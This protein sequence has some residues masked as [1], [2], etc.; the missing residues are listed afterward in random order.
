M[1]SRS[2]SNDPS[3][4]YQ[5]DVFNKVYDGFSY[6]GTSA[7]VWTA[8]AYSWY[9]VE[10]IGYDALYNMA[11]KIITFNVVPPNGNTLTV[12]A[13]PYRAVFIQQKENI[14]I[15]EYGEFQFKILD[16]TIITKEGARQ[17]AFQ[18]IL[19]WS[20]EVTEAEFRT[21]QPGLRVG[22]TINVQSD[23]RGLDTDY[24][25]NHVSAKTRSGSAF[26]YSVTL[27]TTKTMGILYFLQQQLLANDKIE[28]ND[29]EVL[30]ELESFEETLTFTDTT[31]S[32]TLYLGHV[33]SNDAGTTPSHL[34]W[35]GGAD[36]I[37]V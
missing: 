8:T 36:H 33:W 22:Q 16:P 12:L 17:R 9:F 31:I 37:W 27:V 32:T 21:Y 24:L 19:A 7:P 25:I 28:I 15:G 5:I 34:I 1:A 20:Q 13:Q 18:E 29:N 6:A 4:Y 2:G 3:N 14:S 30:D 11:Q 23:I 35:S 26:E 10:V